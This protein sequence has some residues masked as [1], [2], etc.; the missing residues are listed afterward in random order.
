MLP[1]KIAYLR[2]KN[3]G[4]D[5]WIRFLNHWPEIVG[6]RGLILDLR[7][8]GG[9]D[10]F[11]VMRI[12]SVFVT[13]PTLMSH[14]KTPA[15]GRIESTIISPNPKFQTNIPLVI[16]GNKSTACAS[17]EFISTMQNN[18][19]AILVA[20]SRTAGA[21]SMMV[22]L[23]FPD[24]AHARVNSWSVPID[25]SGKR[26]EAIGIEPDVWVYLDSVEDLAHLNDKM[27]EV[28]L[29]ILQ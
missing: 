5:V 9:G 14:M 7:S 18:K 26:K 8:N 22:D 11:S 4:I 13:K 2:L 24:G 10:L 1:E 6:S 19:R 15:D 12:A 17:E 27:R 20:S 25:P 28:A 29:K 16:L 3:W 21:Y 23:V